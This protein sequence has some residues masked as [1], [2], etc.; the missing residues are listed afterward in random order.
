MTTNRRPHRT[1]TPAAPE[2]LAANPLSRRHGD[3]RDER[4]ELLR[5][6]ALRPR[7]P[8]SP[9]ERAT[10]R[11]LLGAELVERAW[12]PEGEPIP[13]SDLAAIQL[14]EASMEKR[15]RLFDALDSS[16]PQDDHPLLRPPASARA[17]LIGDAEYTHIDPDPVVRRALGNSAPL[18]GDFTAARRHLDPEAA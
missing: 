1:V 5:R 18:I 2:V 7:D 17:V 6:V 8:V 11:E 3:K 4:A 14:T 9:A 16:A 13:R 10:L 15:E 12:T